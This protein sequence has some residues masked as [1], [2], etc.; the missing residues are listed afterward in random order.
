[1]KR[2]L[3]WLCV[4]LA[5]PAWFATPVAAEVRAPE[6]DSVTIESQMLD[7]DRRLHVS[8]PD[9]YETGER[10]YPLLFLTDADWNF[11]LVRAYLEFTGDRYPDMIIAG[12]MNTD[13]NR[14]YVPA[15][16]SNFPGTGGA[17]SFL[18]ALSEEILPA[19]DRR[20]R[21]NGRRIYFGHSFGGTFGLHAMLRAP[22][23]FDA[24]IVVGTSTWVADRVLF[25]AAEE[26]LQGGE[27]LDGFLYMSVAEADG[28]E[29]V[30]AGHEFAAL[31]E[32]LA[33]PS[34]EWHYE[35]IPRTTHFT[36]VP[37]SVHRAMDLLFPTWESEQELAAAA[38]EA[39]DG[40]VDDWFEARR[41]ALGFRFHPQRT[42]YSLVAMSLAVDGLEDQ[43]MAIMAQ[44]RRTFPAHPEIPANHAVILATIGR[45]A[46]AVAAIDE[47]I[48][49]GETADYL[50]SRL[51]RFR[52]LKTQFETAAAGEG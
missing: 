42:P 46:E 44:L 37:P 45:H 48:R 21:T 4:T 52:L 50:P 36:A 47:A 8:L 7:E 49:L 32:R 15:V 20:Y 5:W 27:D 1:M 31:L 33:P 41:D 9:G 10:R 34:L 12:I 26:T 43:A 29:T 3:A 24:W 40:A 25:A 51:A 39:G 2:F 38:R 23:L 28:G 6:F 19:L 11:D 17:D 16:D 35:V 30:P 13:R 22:E 14:D 18:R